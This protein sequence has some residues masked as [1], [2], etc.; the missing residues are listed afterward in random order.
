METFAK[1][2]FLKIQEITEHYKATKNQ[3]CTKK[4]ENIQYS[5]TPPE[6]KTFYSNLNFMYP[7]YFFH[8]LS[9]QSNQPTQQPKR[10]MFS[11]SICER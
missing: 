1:Y 2:L 9:S 8:V 7:F 3:F 5:G 10:R 11:Y 6:R 4:Y